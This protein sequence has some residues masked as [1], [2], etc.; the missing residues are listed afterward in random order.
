MG[1]KEKTD[2]S[3]KADDYKP[4]RFIDD[5]HKKQWKINNHKKKIIVNIGKV[6]NIRSA[7]GSMLQN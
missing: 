5:H 6:W 4:D 1:E 7:H 3:F 2:T